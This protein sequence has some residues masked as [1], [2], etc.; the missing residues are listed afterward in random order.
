MERSWNVRLIHRLFS[1]TI[2]LSVVGSFLLHCR[3]RRLH[4]H[5]WS[6]AWFS[7][8]HLT[9]FSVKFPSFLE[10]FTS[11][12]ACSA[13]HKKWFKI[14]HFHAYDTAFALIYDL[15]TFDL[16]SLPRLRTPVF[17]AFSSPLLLLLLFCNHVGPSVRVFC[18]S[19]S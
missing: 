19:R 2:S 13:T 12:R 15:D 10:L 14:H 17:H 5:S 1:T 6:F 3:S 8:S 16:I 11:I 18:G 9:R 4:R 7:E